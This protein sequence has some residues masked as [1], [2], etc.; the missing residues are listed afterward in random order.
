MVSRPALHKDGGRALQSA[1]KTAGKNNGGQALHKDGGQA[2]NL[3]TTAL[4]TDSK[5]RH[6][7]R[8][9]NI[10]LYRSFSA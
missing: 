1:T 9:K 6:S 2:L 7:V 5:K 3:L 4:K 10:R 8:A